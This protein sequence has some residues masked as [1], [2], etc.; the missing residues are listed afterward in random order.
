MPRLL[1]ATATLF[2]VL[3][4]ATNTWTINAYRHRRTMQPRPPRRR[5]VRIRTTPDLDSSLVIQSGNLVP[6]AGATCISMAV[7]ADAAGS[8]AQFTCVPWSDQGWKFGGGRAEG[9]MGR[10]EKAPS[11]RTLCCR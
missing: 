6:Y 11:S 8:L 1:S 4:S 3:A 2:G 5:L 7:D 10:A 9:L